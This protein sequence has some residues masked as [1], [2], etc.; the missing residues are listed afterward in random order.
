MSL[1]TVLAATHKKTMILNVAC[2]N[3]VDWKTGSTPLFH[4]L[5]AG[6]L[7]D[8]SSYGLNSMVDKTY[9]KTASGATNLISM[10]LDVSTARF[11]SQS[12]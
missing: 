6:T 8:E 12:L 2:N 5:N 11:D 7:P 9:D 3:P 10:Y 1:A 4:Y